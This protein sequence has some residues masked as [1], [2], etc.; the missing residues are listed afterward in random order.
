MSIREDKRAEVTERLASHLLG[1]GLSD[2]GLRKLAEIAGTSDRMLLYYFDNKD[3]LLAAVLG[4]IADSMNTALVD[5]FGKQPRPPAE[6]LQQL[7]QVACQ[8][9]FASHLHLWLELS[10]RAG[11]GDAMAMA[12]VSRISTSWTQWLASLLDAPETDRIALANLM[13]AVVDG[14]LVMFPDQLSRGDAAIS[15]LSRHL[16]R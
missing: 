8:P 14:Q 4:H 16:S 2:T 13:L 10:S 6:M 3:E 7:W 9:D 5:L 1:T 15:L 11:R 12:V